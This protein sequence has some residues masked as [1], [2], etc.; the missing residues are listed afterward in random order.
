MKWSWSQKNLSLIVKFQNF[1]AVQI[2]TKMGPLAFLPISESETSIVYSIHNSK[3]NIK[4]DL[5]QLIRKYNF[6]YKIKDRK[7]K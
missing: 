7:I 6:K 5:N 4:E 1:V 2:F 3:D